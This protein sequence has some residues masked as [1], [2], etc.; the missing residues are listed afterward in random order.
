MTRIL[1]RAGLRLE[2]S[3]RTEVQPRRRRLMGPRRPGGG[4]TLVGTL[5]R[6]WGLGGPEVRRQRERLVL[7]VEGWPSGR[8]CPGVLTTCHNTVFKRPPL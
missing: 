3:S 7:K 8:R 2:S 4:R 6:V 5:P 1:Q